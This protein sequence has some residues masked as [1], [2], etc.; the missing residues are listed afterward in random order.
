MKFQLFK[1]HDFAFVR[2][3]ILNSLFLYT[4][5]I[6]YLSICATVEYIGIYLDPHAILPLST[7]ICTTIGL[8]TVFIIVFIYFLI[9]RLIYE[10]EFW[11]IWT[12]YLFL[13]YAFLCPPLRQVSLLENEIISSQFNYYL[14][15]IVFGF[16]LL[17]LCLRVYQ[18]IAIGF[19]K[20][21]RINSNIDEIKS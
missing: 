10:N 1:S 5:S 2:H 21:I 20:K 9:D 8:L 7:S 15:W 3:F 11:S 14:F 12:P 4:T 13:L 18:Q 6:V 19:R 17:L 16:I